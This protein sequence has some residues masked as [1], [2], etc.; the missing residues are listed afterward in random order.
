M[1]DLIYT[2]K[3]LVQSLNEYIKA[4]E[5]KLSAIKSWANKLHTLTRLSTSD[6]EGYLAHPVNAY[7]LMKRLNTEWSELE[8]LVLQNPSEGEGGKGRERRKEGRKEW[9]WTRVV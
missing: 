2:E 9:S 4:E 8:T 6:P 7:K 1:T 3:E 5:S